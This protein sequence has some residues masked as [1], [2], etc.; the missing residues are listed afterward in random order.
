[1]TAGRCSKKKKKK[2]VKG[3][4][5]PQNNILNQFMKRKNIVSYALRYNYDRFK[6]K[7][8]EYGNMAPMIEH[9]ITLSCAI[10]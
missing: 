9:M 7:S 10:C 8:L 2:R 6:N 5:S 4:E 1:M 3:Y